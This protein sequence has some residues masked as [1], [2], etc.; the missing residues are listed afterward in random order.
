MGR[1][2]K[3]IQKYNF[4]TLG[5]VKISDVA[6]GY[7]DSKIVKLIGKQEVIYVCAQTTCSVDIR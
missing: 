5:K 4:L 3:G 2:C 6:S 7:T 1:Q